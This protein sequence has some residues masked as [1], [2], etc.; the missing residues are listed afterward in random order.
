MKGHVRITEICNLTGAS[1]VLVDEPNILP[2]G[3]SYTIASVLSNN[4]STNIEDYRFHY[5]QI[6][7]DSWDLSTFNVSGDVP[8]EEV[9]KNFY[10]LK[11]AFTTAQYGDDSLLSVEDH[12]KII[13]GSQPPMDGDLIDDFVKN[14]GERKNLL[15]FTND[16]ESD[17]LPQDSVDDLPNSWAPGCVSSWSE[18]PQNFNIY[19]LDV[20]VVTSVTGPGLTSSVHSVSATNRKVAAERPDFACIGPNLEYMLTDGTVLTSVLTA[21][22]NQTVSFYIASGLGN[23]FGMKLHDSSLQDRGTL[24][25][26]TGPYGVWQWS[27]PTTAPILQGSSLGVIASADSFRFEVSG[28][29]DGSGFGP[30]RDFFRVEI[31]WNDFPEEFYGDKLEIQLFPIAPP[32]AAEG[33]T[34]QTEFLTDATNYL[35]Y[36][37]DVQVE[38]DISASP[39]HRVH[40]EFSKY[41]YTTDTFAVLPREN[42]TKYGTDYVSIRIVLDTET[43]NDESIKE[44]GLFVKNPD[45]GPSEDKAILVAYKSLD[46][47]INKRKEFSYIVDWDITLTES[48]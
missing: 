44:L 34:V 23:T 9:V 30:N 10:N 16:F 25:S 38:Y 19:P 1:K 12:Q 47:P 32:A 14:P 11:E 28:N 4:G 41:Y 39:Y 48:P 31:S 17:A 22:A 45:G 5:I 26:A 18:L 37:A 42:V 24:A 40:G 33:F 13:V 27:D 15:M 35:S 36:I 43:G 20:C 8:E 7:T 3:L 6:G 2:T 29:P 46:D 21:S